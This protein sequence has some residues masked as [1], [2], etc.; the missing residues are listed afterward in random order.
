MDRL[1]LKLLAA[2]Q[3]DASR[4][5]AALAEEVGLSP[6]SCLRR[7]QRLKANGVIKRTVALIDP[8]AVGRVLRAI[9][10]VELERHGAHHMRTFLAHAKSEPA[11]TH[12][13]AVSGEVDVVLMLR[14]HDMEEFHDL[15]ERLFRDDNNVARFRTLFVMQMAKEETGVPF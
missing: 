3:K 4:T 6:S 8:A 12:A 5:N 9:V 13:Y 15:C 10:E 1:D 14:L 11:V 7:I 2:L